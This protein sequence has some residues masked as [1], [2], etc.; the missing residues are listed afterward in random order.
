VK[1]PAY[2]VR[3]IYLWLRKHPRIGVRNAVRVREPGCLLCN[4]I[5]KN[6]YIKKTKPAA[7]WTY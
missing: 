2:Y 1:I 5:S 4:N 3:F 6:G 7:S